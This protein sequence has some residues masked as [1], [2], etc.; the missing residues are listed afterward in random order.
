MTTDQ[1]FEAALGISKPWYV[2][3]LI[4]EPRQ[5]KLTIR[6]DFE[7]G[8]RFSVLG[9]AGKHPV[10]DTVTKTYRHPNFL[11]HECELE[12][13]VPRARLPDGKVVQVRPPCAGKLSGFT[14]LFDALVLLLAR[15]TSFTGAA[16]IS[17]LSVHRVTALC[18]RYMSESGNTADLNERINA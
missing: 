16:R 18:G 6:V 5:R 9:Q 10:H 13:R 3:G 11:Q 2:A 17:G 8:T 1:V 12:V 4:L 7:V 15:E 14:L